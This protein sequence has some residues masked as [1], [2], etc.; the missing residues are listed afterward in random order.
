MLYLLSA[1]QRQ[2]KPLRSVRN[3]PLADPGSPTLLIGSVRLRS[4]ATR[5]AG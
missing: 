2:A 4:R 5:D 3:D 1:I